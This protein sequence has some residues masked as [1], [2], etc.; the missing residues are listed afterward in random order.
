MRHPEM[1]IAKS[2]HAAYIKAAE[3]FKIKLITLPVGRDF[4][5]SGEQVYVCKLQRRTL[6]HRVFADIYH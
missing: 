2:A 5:L 3:Y 6:L 4:R 1:I